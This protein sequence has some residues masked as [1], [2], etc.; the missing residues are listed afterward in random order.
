MAITILLIVAIG[1]LLVYSLTMLLNRSRA[2]GI[3]LFAISSVSLFFVLNP[4]A[5]TKLANFLG[6]GRGADL[7]LY[8]TF[9]FLVFIFISTLVGFR[10][11]EHTVTELAREQA[12]SAAESDSKL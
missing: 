3:S 5:T 7:L 1:F 9:I 12:L 10:K 2:M 8:V 4:L 6:V 11:L